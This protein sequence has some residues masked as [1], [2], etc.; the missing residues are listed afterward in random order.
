MKEGR[1]FV[2]YNGDVYHDGPCTF[3]I[4]VC[5]EGSFLTVGKQGETD[6]INHFAIVFFTG[7]DEGFAYLPF[8]PEGRKTRSELSP[9]KAAAGAT[10]SARSAPG[11]RRHA[12][13]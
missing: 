2:E 10:P 12:N 3:A 7:G 11:L 13:A 1:C 6:V 4:L 8:L 5:P 9:E